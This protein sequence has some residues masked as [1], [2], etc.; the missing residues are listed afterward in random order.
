MLEEEH[1]VQDGSSTKDRDAVLDELFTL[2]YTRIRRQAHRQIAREKPGGTLQATELLHE[3]YIRLQASAPPEWRDQV[4]FLRTVAR[5]MRRALIDVARRR[6]SEKRGGRLERVPL[7]TLSHGTVLAPEDVMALDT[8]LER[9]SKC[10]GNGVREARVLEWHFFAG[11]SL[12]EIAR[13]LGVSERT[14]QRDFAHA[15]I[16][17]KREIGV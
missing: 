8:A 11:A 5:S 2:L 12:A 1:G 14:V 6:K 3:A 7:V 13:A 15:R 17:L 10:G 9:L 16:W 4:H